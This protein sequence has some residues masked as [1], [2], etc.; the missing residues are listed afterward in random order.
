MKRDVI[1]KPETTHRNFSRYNS[2]DLRKWEICP[3]TVIDPRPDHFDGVLCEAVSAPVIN[4]DGILLMYN[5]AV[6]GEYRKKL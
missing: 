3:D 4:D 6:D 5:G 2:K 1:I